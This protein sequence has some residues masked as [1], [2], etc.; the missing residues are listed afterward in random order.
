MK[1]ASKLEKQRLCKRCASES[2]VL[3]EN[4]V[5]GWRGRERDESGDEA[6]WCK[7]AAYL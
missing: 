4:D 5:G 2:R 1:D 7:P 6:N 3:E